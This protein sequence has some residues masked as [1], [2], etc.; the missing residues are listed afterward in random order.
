M[1]VI[2][3]GHPVLTLGGLFLYGFSNSLLEMVLA[4]S[5]DAARLHIIVFFYCFFMVFSWLLQFLEHQWTCPGIASASG[6]VKLVLVLCGLK[7]EVF[8]LQSCDVWTETHRQSP[9]VQLVIKHN[10]RLT[11]CQRPYFFAYTK[12]LNWF[13]QPYL[14]A[15]NHI[16]H[17]ASYQRT[18][19]KSGC[20]VDHK[21][22]KTTNNQTCTHDVLSWQQ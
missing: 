9:F 1:L 15:F 2:S 18:L 6:I 7:I 13:L 4:A 11:I 19:Q 14:C 10:L 22:Q 20:H 5:R 12:Q 16:S 21:K 3:F 17:D 8:K